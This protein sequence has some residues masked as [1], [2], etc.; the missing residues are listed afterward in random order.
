MP[1]MPK[2]PK[3]LKKINPRKCRQIVDW[4]ERSET[5]Q[6]WGL[7][8]LGKPRP[9]GLRLVDPTARPPAHRGL[10]PGGR[11]GAESFGYVC[12]C[13]PKECLSIGSLEY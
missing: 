9:L 2:V 7:F 13:Y 4:V 11:A 6:M 10:R 8:N 5:H 3:I 12:I 1:K